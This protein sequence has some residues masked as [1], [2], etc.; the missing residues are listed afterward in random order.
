MNLPQDT[1]TALHALSVNEVQV[2]RSMPPSF[3]TNE[4]MLPAEIDALFI[5]G[6]VCVGRADEIPNIG[7]FYTL[8]LFSEPLIVTRKKDN[9][10]A[11]LSN[12]CRHR[13]SQ[14]LQ[15]R[16][17]KKRFTCPYHK[18]A[19]ALDGSLITA[20][21]VQKTEGFDKSQC[22]LPSFQIHIWYGWIFVNLSGN[23]EDFEKSIVG[24][25]DYVHN[26]HAEEMRS[27]GAETE[28]WSLN[29]K[30]LAENFME[31]YHLS[32]VHKKTLHPMTP[33]KLCEKIPGGSGYTG[34][35]SHY[36]DTYNGRNQYHAD[37]TEE[38]RSQS[39]MVW[40]YPGFVAAISP[41]SAV[42]MSITPTGSTQL[43]TRWDVIAREE[44][45]DDGEATERIEFARSFNAEDRERLLDVQAGLRSRFA[46]SGFLA[47][48]DYEGTVWDFYHY[49]ADRLLKTQPE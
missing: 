3:Y 10:V 37:M 44:V 48:P 17:N 47:P 31:G 14:I 36:S 16:G 8:E 32:P 35:K 22:Q 28:Q 4:H 9:D 41:N 40:I 12:V 38:E 29:W 49:V 1:Y 18:W 45:F 15:G 21:L 26:Y 46:A 11:V 33:T 23:A 30:V 42:Y 43:Q 5:E 20:P 25:N 39:M 27:I 6:W 7:D 2:P 24:L 19:Y 34:Y 13:G